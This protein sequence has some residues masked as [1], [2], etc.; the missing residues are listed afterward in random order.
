[1]PIS[2]L[3]PLTALLVSAI[4]CGSSSPTSPSSLDSVSISV[5]GTGV[6]TYTYT[7]NIAPILTTD[8]VSCHNATNKQSGVNLSTYAGVMAV[9]TAGSAN[10]ILVKAVQPAGPMYTNL[11]GSRTTKVQ[12]I[13]DW[14]VNSKA[15]Q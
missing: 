15:A 6:S 10:S 7:A 13:Y 12:T 11:S 5:T 2:R 4:A 3:L 9:V 1:M 8:C 14:V